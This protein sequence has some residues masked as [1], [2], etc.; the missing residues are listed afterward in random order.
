MSKLIYAKSKEGLDILINES[1]AK[2]AE[3]DKALAFTEDGYFYTHGQY[4]KL[5]VKGVED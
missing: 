1:V 4:F 5:P 3:V 2:K